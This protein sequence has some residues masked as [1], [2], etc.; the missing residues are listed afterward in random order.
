MKKGI[1]ASTG[2]A[3]G[4][5]FLK[6]LH[7]HTIPEDN[8][9]NPAVE[10][11]KL[12]VAVE[13]SQRQLLELIEK[14]RREMGEAEAAIFQSHLS[15]LN[16]PEFTGAAAKNIESHRVSAV[17]AVQDVMTTY[18]ELFSGM[19]DEYW[20]EKAADI[21]DV[22]ERL[23][24]NLMGEAEQDLA[25][26]AENTVVVAHDL[27]PS[28][29]ARIDR[30]KVVAFLTDTGGPTSH[31]AIMART[32][33]IPAVVGLEDITASVK[34]GDRIIVDGVEGTVIVNPD[35]ET[36]AWYEDKKADVEQ[37]RNTL[38]ALVNTKTVTRSGKQ[39]ILAGN[40]GSPEDVESLT[41]NGAEGVG[42]FRTEFL[43]M[44][45]NTLPDEEEQF[46]AYRK[47]AEK[48][49]GKPVVIRTL[50]IGGDKKLS[51]LP[52]PEEM[53]PFLGLRAIRLCLE[54]RA[55]F[56]SQLRAIL[57]ASAYGNVQVM[58]P[59]IGSVDEFLKAKEVLAESMAELRKAGVPFREKIETGIMIEVP[60]AALIAGELA[61]HADFFSI[62]TNDLT[63]YTLA[64]DR[65]NKS[66]SYL[67]N[68][69][70]PAVLKLIRMTVDA[71]HREG[72]WCGMCGE[73]AGEERAIPVLMEYG[74]DE[75][76]MNASAILPIRRI[77]LNT[78]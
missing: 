22:G 39:V 14:T 78:G 40:I 38:K 52:F 57:R 30:K 54:K 50:D 6:E 49:A 68:P 45:R 26:L 10:K 41:A 70:H 37:T 4:K 65:T 69:M 36:V 5:V 51:Y 62:G 23:L 35:D 7:E 59:M 29:T 43:Y 76:S 66:V 17:R 58:F 16:D 75:L 18:I 21:Q 3:I 63:Q 56:K 31:S 1:P 27:T 2:Y 60:S 9:M 33:G 34:N 74:L 61:K 28:D 46:A 77:I 71:A 47:V 8:E 42:L 11:E 24:R 53:N 72:K 73:M 25:H 12:T 19:E 44:D 15:F 32:L 48:M 64:V 20:R 13:S 67:Y 55:L